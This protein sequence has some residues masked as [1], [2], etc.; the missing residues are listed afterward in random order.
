MFAALTC[1]ERQ[2]GVSPKDAGFTSVLA[3]PYTGLVS[4]L[5]ET[6]KVTSDVTW[7]PPEGVEEDGRVVGVTVSYN[8]KE[9]TALLLWSL[10]RVLEWW[11]LDVV[12]VDNGSSDGSSELLAD[13]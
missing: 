4:R 12:V 11:S 7:W 1:R 10:Y 9:L 3:S 8:T 13:A 2:G 5:G 6:D